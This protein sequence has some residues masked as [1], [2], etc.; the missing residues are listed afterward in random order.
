MIVNGHRCGWF[1]VVDDMTLARVTIWTKWKRLRSLAEK[2][3]CNR[4]EWSTSVWKMAKS[5]SCSKPK[6]SSWWNT[7]INWVVGGSFRSDKQR[8]EN[9]QWDG[10][11]G[12]RWEGVIG[13]DWSETV[14]KGLWA[15]N[16]ENEIINTYLY[17]ISLYIVGSTCGMG[18]Y[19]NIGI[20]FSCRI[21]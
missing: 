21:L 10:G 9:V 11:G 17:T 18:Y 20:F 2:I 3:D 7:V 4:G 13:H 19:A 14:W 1:G 12:G 6:P 16:G 15:V 8:R 5:S